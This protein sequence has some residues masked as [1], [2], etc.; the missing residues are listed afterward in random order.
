MYGTE[1]LQAL[2]RHHIAL[3]E[4]LAQQV[5]ADDRSAAE[6]SAAVGGR[7]AG[8]V[9]GLSK[10]AVA[11]RTSRCLIWGPH[12]WLLCRFELAAPPRFGLV[13]LRL[14]GVGSNGNRELLAA[15]NSAGRDVQCVALPDQE[16]ENKPFSCIKQRMLDGSTQQHAAPAHSW[17]SVTD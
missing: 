13:C 12:C 7:A 3:G 11:L 4:W 5:A 17:Y 10:P 9:C 6:T 16:H 14:K 1:K 15:V 2:V 8:V